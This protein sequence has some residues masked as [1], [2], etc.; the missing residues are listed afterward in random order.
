MWRRGVISYDTFASADNPQVLGQ[1]PPIVLLGGLGMPAASGE[2][3]GLTP[4][5]ERLARLARRGITE[6]TFEFRLSGFE[7]QEQSWPR[8]VAAALIVA[9]RRVRAYLTRHA[10]PAEAT[11]AIGGVEVHADL[12]GAD[13]LCTA[14]LSEFGPGDLVLVQDEVALFA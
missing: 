13:I 2:G 6:H 14:Q 4:A 1:G 9:I 10:E 8:G 12:R 3:G 7:R 5:G 11:S